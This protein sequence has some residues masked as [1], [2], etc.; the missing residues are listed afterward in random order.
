MDPCY[1][2]IDGFWPKGADRKGLESAPITIYYYSRYE[3]R[4]KLAP[5]PNGSLEPASVMRQLIFRKSSWVANV[6]IEQDAL[7]VN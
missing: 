4:R 7:G 3:L 1:I 2:D 6:A 5:K